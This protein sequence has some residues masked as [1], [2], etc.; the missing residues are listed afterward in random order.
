MIRAIISEA[1][2]GVPSREPGNGKGRRY[3]EDKTE[4]IS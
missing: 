1:S 4:A 2:T 3:V